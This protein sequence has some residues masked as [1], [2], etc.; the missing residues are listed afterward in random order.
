MKVCDFIAAFL[1]D[2]KYD[3]VFGYQGGAVT[4][5]IDS[6]SKENINFIQCRHEQAS[7]FAADAAARI[8]NKCQI[9]IATN[10][11]GATN[12]VS[13][14]ANAYLDSVPVLFIVGQ[15]MCQDMK[16]DSIRQNGFQ[17]VDSS[18]ITKSITKYSKCIK[19]ADEVLYELQKAVFTAET[20]RK[21]AVL[22]EIPLDILI[23]EIDDT[24]LKTFDKIK[25]EYNI[26]DIDEIV[27]L[28]KKA[29]KPIIVA[30]GGI[31]L[32]SA[33]QELE[34]F[35]SKTNI[36]MVT[37]LMGKDVFAK[38][39]IGF[40]GL[41]GQISAN[42]ALYNSDLVMFLGSRLAKRQMGGNLK[43]YCPFAKTINIDIDNFELNRVKDTDIKINCDLNKFLNELNKYDFQKVSDNW[44]FQIQQWQDKYK[45]EI[46]KNPECEPVKHIEEISNFAD[47][48]YIIT[49]DVGQNQMWCAQAWKIKNG[50]RF[51]SSGGLGCMGFS[52]PAAIGA[53]FSQPSK[54]VIA[55]MG[56]GGFQM[57]LQELETVA[58]N[59][60]NIKIVIFNN[61]SLGMI[62]EGQLKYHSG[63]YIGTKKG[64]SCPNIEKVA[65]AFNFKYFSSD[66]KEKFMQY[67]DKCILEIKLSQNPTRVF[68][69]YDRNDVFS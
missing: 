13:A 67:D 17:E 24:K 38:T 63:N 4:P 51:L 46:Y 57:N 30:G 21:G 22:L 68:V 2:K 48:D 43:K 39:N 69:K 19:S 28:L 27:S 6:I 36:P 29:E 10:G 41:Y 55:F 47:K 45:E 56:D 18:S 49:T 26:N 16:T 42:L 5:L 12:L 3:K 7:G 61:N 15:V 66:K 64:Y 8:S 20:G 11:P 65:N 14:I 34:N 50:Q 59:H 1:K 35:I 44:S 31:R 23:S 33:E 62:Q 40:S 25:C 37:T 58:D 32:A 9:V 54:K 53:K 60:L 52:L